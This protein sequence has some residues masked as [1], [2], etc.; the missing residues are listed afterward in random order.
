MA[1]AEFFEF[2]AGSVELAAAA[3]DED[4]FGEGR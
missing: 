2:G 3:V 1:E 4:E